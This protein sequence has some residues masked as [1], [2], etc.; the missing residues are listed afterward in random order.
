MNLKIFPIPIIIAVWALICINLPAA[1]SAP[2]HIPLSQSQAGRSNCQ[3]TAPDYLGPYYKAGAP[4]RTRVGTGYELKG[5]VRS[6]AN[7]APIEK[8]RI[9]F[10]LTS[11]DGEYDDD[12]RATLF[13][14][15]A[16][17]YRFESNFPPGYSGRPP[18]IHIKISANGFKT[19]TTQHYP[20]TGSRNGV[21]D[22]VLVPMN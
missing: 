7:C 18:H 14:D 5:V 12:H 20:Q 2:T 16:G 21:F 4:E 3:P 17:N 15:H 19:L 8:A 9:E 6:A 13:S 11:S 22:I 1:L 10:W